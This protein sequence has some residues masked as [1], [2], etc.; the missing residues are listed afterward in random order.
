MRTAFAGWA[1]AREREDQI[2]A[3]LIASM[4]VAAVANAMLSDAIETSDTLCLVIGLAYGLR[5]RL[6]TAP[7]TLPSFARRP[8][9]PARI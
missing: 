2:M 1:A 9:L 7:A 4:V 6:A 8:F 3:A 5:A